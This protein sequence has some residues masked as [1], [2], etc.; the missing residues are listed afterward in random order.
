[1]GELIYKELSYTITGF[2]FKTHKQ[3]GRFCR[4]KQYSDFLD[5]ILHDSELKY[6]REIELKIL[7]EHS[8]KGNR[9]DFIIEDKIILDLK[10]KPFI[11]REDYNQMQRYL[12]AANIELGLIVNFRSYYLKPKRILNTK[13]FHSDNSDENSDY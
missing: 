1:M 2:L 13:I 12:Q 4:E 3:L 7:E 6:Q 11:L 10:A 8:P 5:K 9:V